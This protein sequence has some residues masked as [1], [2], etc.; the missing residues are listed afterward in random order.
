[1]RDLLQAQGVVAVDPSRL[2]LHPHGRDRGGARGDGPGAADEAAGPPAAVAII[3]PL[4]L[5][6]AGAL[7]ARIPAPALVRA[8]A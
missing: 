4:Q 3:H 6:L 5:F 2:P 1:M 8:A 7:L